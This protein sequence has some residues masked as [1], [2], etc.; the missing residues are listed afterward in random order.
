[1]TKLNM[2][3]P[4][5]VKHIQGRQLGI[6]DNHSSNYTLGKGMGLRRKSGGG[7]GMAKRLQSGQNYDRT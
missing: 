7:T 4:E 6:C 5:N 3:G 2:Q 1:M